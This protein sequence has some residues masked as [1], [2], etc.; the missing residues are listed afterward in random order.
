ML[1]VKNT[2][3]GRS[4]RS[5]TAVATARAYAEPRPNPSRVAEFPSP[6][7]SKVTAPSLVKPGDVRDVQMRLPVIVGEA[8]YKGSIP[9]DGIINGQMGATTGLNLRQKCKNSL[10]CEPELSGEISFRDMLRVNGFIAGSVYSQSGTL[11][12]DSSSR[13]DANVDVGVAVIGGVVNGDI[14][15]RQRVELGPNARIHGNIWTRSI[16]IKDGA[17][18]EGVC[19]MI[20]E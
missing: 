5:A 18:F 17:V 19:R 4:E 20:E 1:E 2:N 10:T 16:Q 12:V 7:T 14:V 6:Q 15:A 11:I 9:V 13:V 3:N 8:H